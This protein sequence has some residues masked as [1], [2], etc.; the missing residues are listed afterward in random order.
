MEET[1]RLN[2]LRPQGTK[3]LDSDVVSQNAVEKE[4][5]DKKMKWDCLI[6]PNSRFKI[7]WDLVIIILSVYNSILIPYDFAYQVK[8]SIMLEI[9]DRTIDC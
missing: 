9:L 7:T 5:I 8:T 2:S 3:N 4:R 1:H 6:Y